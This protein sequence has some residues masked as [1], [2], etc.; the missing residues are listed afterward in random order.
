MKNEILIIIYFNI[1]FVNKIHLFNRKFV[2]NLKLIKNVK[3]LINKKNFKKFR[4]FFFVQLNIFQSYTN[5]TVIMI[6]IIFYFNHLDQNYSYHFLI[7]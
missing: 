2:K 3:T 4:F 1:L 6:H 5:T 7:E